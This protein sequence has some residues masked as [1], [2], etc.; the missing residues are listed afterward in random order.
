MSGC[1]GAVQKLLRRLG[2][3]GDETVHPLTG[4]HDGVECGDPAVSGL[5]EQVGAV[6][7]QDVEEEHRK[8]LGRLR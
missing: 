7:M 1:Q 2:I 8:R 6:E 3:S 5:V 4:G